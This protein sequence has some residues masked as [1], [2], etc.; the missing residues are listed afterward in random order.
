MKAKAEENPTKPH[1]PSRK[2]CTEQVKTDKEGFIQVH[3]NRGER[4]NAT[5]LK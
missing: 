5:S 2:D 4:L 3:C 1:K